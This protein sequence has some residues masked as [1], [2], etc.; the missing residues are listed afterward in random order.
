MLSYSRIEEG[1]ECL[2]QVQLE[3]H[4]QGEEHEQVL[5]GPCILN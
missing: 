1:E 2:Q 5:V 4:E 3:P